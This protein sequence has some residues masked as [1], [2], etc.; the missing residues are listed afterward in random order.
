MKKR[1]LERSP[2]EAA[3]LEATPLKLTS[4]QDKIMRSWVSRKED[5]VWDVYLVFDDGEELL[6]SKRD[7]CL[8]SEYFATMFEGEFVESAKPKV[9]IKDVDSSVMVRMI[10]SYYMGKV[11]TPHMQQPA[12]GEGFRVHLQRALIIV[13]AGSLP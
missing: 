3:P 4:I 6:C 13:L 5:K 8:M 9:P 12:E 11:R 7:L 1:K 10:E 2:I